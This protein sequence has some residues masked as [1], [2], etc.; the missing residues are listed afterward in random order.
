MHAGWREPYASLP[1]DIIPPIPLKSSLSNA[2]VEPLLCCSV[3]ALPPG[4]LGDVAQEQG[5]EVLVFDKGRLPLRPG[6][7]EVE[8]GAMFAAYSV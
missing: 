1:G 8:L 5:V 3:M 7:S 2:A 4:K 6:I